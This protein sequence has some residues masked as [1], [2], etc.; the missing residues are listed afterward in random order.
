MN[1][2]VQN[3]ILGTLPAPKYR[4][5]IE[6]VCRDIEAGRLRRGDLLPSIN[7]RARRDGLSRDTV[8]KAYAALREMGLVESAH[9]KGFYIAREQVQRTKRLFVLFD[10]FTPY[11]EILYE[12]FRAEAAGR[13][14]WE[15]F[16]HHF[17]PDLFCQLLEDARGRYE[18]Y[19]VMPFPHPKV[20]R[21]LAAFDPGRLL[22]LDIMVSFRGKRCAEVL[23]SHDEELERALGEA[24]DRIR[25]YRS[26][27]L[28]FPEDRGHPQVIK[29]AFRRFCR[30]KG[31]R[32]GIV[33]TLHEADIR[34]G[35]AWFV[36]EDSDLV[37]LI[38]TC[39]A[40]GFRLGHDV[41]VVS[42]NDTPMKEV[43]QDGISVISIDFAELGRKA[44]RLALDL[45]PGRRVVEPTRFISRNSL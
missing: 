22:L 5:I 37:R 27:T 10:A 39:R 24:E 43:V 14:R 28:V 1:G 32:G 20:L 35:H 4:R 12:A 19:V 3:S 31:I 16:F 38:K 2:T 15:I 9:G 34:P 23:Q 17:H 36:I 8:V 26:L 45:R 21:T 44:A 40:R 11:K 25:R 7:R 42:Y 13:A 29:P 41:G 30:R 18:A 33:E 6:E